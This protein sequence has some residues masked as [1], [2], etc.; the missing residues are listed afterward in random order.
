MPPKSS[1]TLVLNS[2]ALQKD[3][4]FID[5]LSTFQFRSCLLNETTLCQ[6]DKDIHKTHEGTLSLNSSKIVNG[7]LFE[8]YHETLYI[9]I[10]VRA[11]SIE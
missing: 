2:T 9:K 3:I 11:Y 4:V 10:E 8:N 5:Y 1:L 6:H 7:I